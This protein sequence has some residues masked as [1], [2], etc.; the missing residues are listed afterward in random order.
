MKGKKKIAKNPKARSL[1]KPDLESEDAEFLKAMG[2]LDL[3]GS[4]NLPDKDRDVPPVEAPQKQGSFSQRK[5]RRDTSRPME[6]LDL[7]G[8]DAEQAVRRLES[9]IQ[10][11]RA[12]GQREVLVIT[13][14]GRRSSGAPVL[15]QTV[16]RWL[17]GRGRDRVERFE[18][19]HPRLGGRG[20]MVLTLKSLRTS[21]Q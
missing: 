4:P 14:K 19:A 20:A 5:R 1:P 11:T 15:K 8:T 7:H 18:D 10:R 2:R 3:Q 9:F 13:G 21:G 17:R 12:S 6:K 16:L